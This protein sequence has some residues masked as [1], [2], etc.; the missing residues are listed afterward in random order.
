MIRLPARAELHQQ[1]TEFAID[2]DI[3][4]HPWLAAEQS[5]DGVERQQQLMRRPLAAAPPNRQIV[6]TIFDVFWP[7]FKSSNERHRIVQTP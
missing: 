7:H 5:C 3:R 2:L 6:E 4:N 1:F